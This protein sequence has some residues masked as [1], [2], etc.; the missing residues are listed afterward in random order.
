M[1]TKI[2]SKG[3]VVLPVELRKL[4]RLRPGQRFDIERVNEGQYLFKRQPASDNQ[5]MVDWLQECPEKDWF[6][7]LPSESTDSL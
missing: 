3:Q 1:Q 2:S 5:G 4:D 6:Q 7:L